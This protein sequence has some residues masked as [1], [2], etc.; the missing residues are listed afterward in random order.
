MLSEKK[1]KMK[2]AEEE[3][4]KQRRRR[5]RRRSSHPV[6]NGHTCIACIFHASVNGLTHAYIYMC[7]HIH[8]VVF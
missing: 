5:R 1:E 4:E 3:K 8:S 2:R 7:A 6:N